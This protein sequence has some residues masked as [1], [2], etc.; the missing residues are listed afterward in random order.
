LSAQNYEAIVQAGFPA[1]KV[2]AGSSGNSND[3]GQY[4]DVEKV[5]LAPGGVIPTLRSK[6][7][8][9]FGGIAWGQYFDAQPGGT[10]APWK[11]AQLM[12]TALNS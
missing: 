9:S 4:V 12:N 1:N 11:W 5:L 10:A 6:Y 2:V 8:S 3:A 7:G